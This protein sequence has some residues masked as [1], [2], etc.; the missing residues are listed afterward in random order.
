MFHVKRC[1]IWRCEVVPCDAR[2]CHDTSTIPY[3]TRMY[4]IWQQCQHHHQS[5]PKGLLVSN[6]SNRRRIND[7][8]CPQVRLAAPIIKDTQRWSFNTMIHAP[9]RKAHSRKTRSSTL[10]QGREECRNNSLGSCMKCSKWNRGHFLLV[11]P[12]Q[13]EVSE[14]QTYHSSPKLSSRNGSR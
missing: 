6:F 13:V 8:L 10:A 5:P 7:F 4:D 2:L 1:H 12:Q 11:G 14:S 9:V 3:H